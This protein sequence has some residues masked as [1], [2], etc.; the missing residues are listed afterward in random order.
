[1]RVNNNSIKSFLIAF[2]CYALCGTASATMH[3]KKTFFMPRPQGSNLV[4]ELSLFHDHIFNVDNKFHSHVQAV[5]FYQGSINGTP[6]GKYFGV[7]NGSNSFTIG[8]AADVQVSSKYLFHNRSTDCPSGTMIF[9]PKQEVYGVRLDFFQSIIDPGKKLFLK[10][11][12]PYVNV[13]N[14]MHFK[15]LE[16]TEDTRH[17]TLSNFFHG[18]AISTSMTSTQEALTKGKISGRRSRTGFSNLDFNF[19]YKFVNNKK[20]HLFVNACVSLPTGN[21]PRGEYLFEPVYGNGGH[22]AVGL[23]ADASYKLWKR[24]RHCGKV[25]AALN[26]KYIFDG[27][28]TRTIPVKSSLGSDYRGYT[29]AHYYLSVKNGQLSSAGLFPAANVLTQKVTVRPG[30]ELDGLL[31][32][33]FK[34]KRF[35]IDLGYEAYYKE[36]EAITLKNWNDDVYA[37]VKDDFIY[38]RVTGNFDITSDAASILIKLN[39]ENLDINGAGTPSQ[40]T[41]KIFGSLGYKFSMGKYPT[42][43]GLGGSYEFATSNSELEGY[44]IWGKLA[45]S[46]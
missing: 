1:M 20:S 34:T 15:V 3:S 12:A 17:E 43:F 6:I 11:S 30:N 27:S 4:T 33:N 44:A 39:R 29:F 41:N 8:T 42:T 9:N 23:G 24:E 16:E 10:A 28:E 40:F 45:M 31:M 5:P 22:V 37:I 2:I 35:L 18:D 32:L 14:D 13:S 36:N 26:Y 25:T 19:G 7:G 21:K 46:F 38:N